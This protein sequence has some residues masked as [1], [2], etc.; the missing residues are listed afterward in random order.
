MEALTQIVTAYLRAQLDAGAAAVQLF[1]SWVGDLPAE[2]YRRH[3]APHTERI[4]A[5]TQGDA[6][7]IVF[8]VGTEELL[9]LM[10]SHGAEVVGVDWRVPLDDA[11][12]RVGDGV[13][14][15]GNLDPALC[16]A[17]WN[18]LRDRALDILAR[19]G[20]RGHVFNLGHGVHP[21]TDPDALKRLVDLVHAWEPPR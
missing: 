4:L 11:R 2:D 1:D 3:V 10:A 19:G 6:P 16:L 7:R 14:L 9:P 21:D 8:G 13:A 15:Q 12:R 17:P 5:G 20:G 18:V